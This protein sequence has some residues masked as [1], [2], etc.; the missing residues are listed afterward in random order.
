MVATGFTAFA[1][2]HNRLDK[3]IRDPVLVR[4]FNRR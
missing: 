1:S 4:P 3:L 2:Y